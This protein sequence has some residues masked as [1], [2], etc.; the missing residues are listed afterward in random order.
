M[1]SECP[2]QEVELKEVAVKRG[3]LVVEE[4]EREE[5]AARRRLAAVDGSLTGRIARLRW[6]YAGAALATGSRHGGGAL[7]SSGSGAATVDA[8]VACK[9]Q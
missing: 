1:T 3:E 6:Q 2:T 9:V 7:P 4:A 8:Q 5:A